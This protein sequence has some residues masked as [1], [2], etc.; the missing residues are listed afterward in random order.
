MN[1]SMLAG[2][3]VGAIIGYFTNSIAVHMLFRPLHAIKIGNFTLPFTPGLIPKGQ[4]RLAKAIGTTVGEQLLTEDV[5]IEN[6][7]SDDM[8][9]KVSEGVREFVEDQSTNTDSLHEVLC[10]YMASEKIDEKK[11]DIDNMIVDTIEKYLKVMNLGNVVSDEVLKAVNQY[12]KG[13]FLAMMVNDDILR[14]IANKI[15]EKVNEYVE[16]DGMLFIASAIDKETDI[17]LHQP[18]AV[19]GEKA[20]EE[21]ETIQKIVISSYEAFVRNKMQ[22]FLQQINISKIV[23]DKI[24]EMDVA[25]L[26]KL[27][28]SIMKKELNAVINLGAVIG[29]VIGIINVFI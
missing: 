8:K 6:L 2:P 15:E 14:P 22:Q 16:N 10:Q 18:I 28:L 26:E 23:E 21:K 17:L 20:L 27:V 7:L 1:L 9:N 19:Y 12:I 4:S 29:F 25:E 11:D 24:N 5:L 3:I 13:T